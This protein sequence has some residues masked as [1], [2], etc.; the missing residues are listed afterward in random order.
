ML[1]NRALRH[2]PLTFGW[3]AKH[4]VPHDVVDGYA[5]PLL[6]DAAVRK[7]VIK[8]VR[9]VSNKQTLQAADRLRAFS[10]PVLLA[11]ARED[12]VFK[13]ALADQPEGLARLIIDF[14]RTGRCPSQG[15]GVRPESG[16][17]PP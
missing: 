8:F 16:A 7:D 12:R 9:G 14:A 6:R 15:R 11:W 1:R 10:K 3:L 17:R 2:T 5:A 13:P 4:G